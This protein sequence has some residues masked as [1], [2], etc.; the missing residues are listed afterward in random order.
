MVLIRRPA[1]HP[2]E[3]AAV[4]IANLPAVEE[5]LSSGA[6]VAIL[7]DRIR[8]RRLPMGGSEST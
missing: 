2:D 3:Q 6:V 8:V 4:L 7:N 1:K 5:D